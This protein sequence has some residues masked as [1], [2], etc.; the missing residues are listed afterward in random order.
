MGLTLVWSLLI[1]AI[2]SFFLTSGFLDPGTEKF[3]F[4]AAQRRRCPPAALSTVEFYASTAWL[5]IL[6]CTPLLAVSIVALT[7]AHSLA[8]LSRL[9][10]LAGV[11]LLAVALGTVLFA[12]AVN[13]LRRA[14]FGH[15]RLLLISLVFGPELLRLID[16]SLWTC[17]TLLASVPEFI[18]SWSHLS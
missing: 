12:I 8:E 14:R 10:L 16:P 13:G 3:L 18:L 1:A 6:A 11:L 7:R 5:L 15:P 2:G 4:G 17:R 9:A